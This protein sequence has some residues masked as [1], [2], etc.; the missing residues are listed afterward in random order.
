MLL[1]DIKTHIKR[2]DI[3]WN[4]HFLMPFN[5]DTMYSKS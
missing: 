3:R 4:Q 2:Y 5:K 1:Q